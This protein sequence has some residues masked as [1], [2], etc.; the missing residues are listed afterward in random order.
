MLLPERPFSSDKNDTKNTFWQNTEL[1][2][3]ALAS[4][5]SVILHVS[6]T[7]QKVVNYNKYMDHKGGGSCWYWVIKCHGIFFTWRNGGENKRL[8][9]LKR[10]HADC[11]DYFDFVCCLLWKLERKDVIF[12]KIGHFILPIYTEHI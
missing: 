12:G 8:A 7:C 2:F 1:L 9:F 4:I 3:W 11:F 10:N 6:Y 5:T